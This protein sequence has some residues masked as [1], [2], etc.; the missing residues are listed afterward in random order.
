MVLKSRLRKNVES[1]FHYARLKPRIAVVTACSNKKESV[2]SP[3]WKL[4][5][6]SRIKHLYRNSSNYDFYI[7]S[8]KYG[9]IKA[10]EIIEPYNE[11]MSETKAEKLALEVAKKLASFDYVIYYK[12][13]A[14]QNYLECIRKACGMLKKTLIIC[15]FNMIGGINDVKIIVEYLLNS[16]MEKIKQIDHVSLYNFY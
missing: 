15:G 6:S 10:D 1:N 8:A 11:I 13:G 4:Y 5:K 7:L 12:C 2:P 9:L 16:E 3:A 14:N